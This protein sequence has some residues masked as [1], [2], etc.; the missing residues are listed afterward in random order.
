MRR[1][2]FSYKVADLQKEV[3]KRTSYLGKMRSTKEAQHL[4]DRL[5]LTE[6]EN[7]LFE[8]Y[9]MEAA[10]RTYDWL[11][12]FGR[13][14]P[15]AMLANIGTTTHKLFENY[16]LSIKVGSKTQKGS[17]WIQPNETDIDNII[18]DNDGD[19]VNVVSIEFSNLANEDM[20]VKYVFHH[21]IRTYVVDSDGNELPISD[22]ITID[23]ER[24]ILID[25]A[26]SKI[27]NVEITKDFRTSQYGDV[28]GVYRGC[29]AEL[30]DLIL[31]G[32][33]QPINVGDYVEEVC[34][35]NG[36]ITLWKM[37]ERCTSHNW[38]TH[39]RLCLDSDDRESIVYTLDCPA[40]Q[41]ENMYGR[42][43]MSIKEAIVNYVI[44]LWFEVVL[45]EEA[46]AFINKA[47]KHGLDTQM[48]LNAEKKFLRRRY[49]TF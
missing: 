10:G 16:G 20:Q 41:D 14:V 27:E 47:E 15:K 3:E 32:V 44:G 46:E 29:Y 24:E 9:L 40:W 26:S 13:N 2:V 6:S 35:E 45:S 49:N 48:A 39:D 34:V 42:V 23:E 36:N 21:M 4:L 28:K 7:F 22:D 8:Q 33:A 12:A 38:E 19:T 17:F 5:A 1:C 25:V 37:L 43:D 30:K 31:D 18:L 11:Q